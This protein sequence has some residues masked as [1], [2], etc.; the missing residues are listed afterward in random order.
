MGVVAEVFETETAVCG[1][2]QNVTDPQVVASGILNA[3]MS[4]NGG[5][6]RKQQQVMLK[7]MGTAYDINPGAARE[8]AFLGNWLAAQADTPEDAVLVLSH[9]L[10]S[11]RGPMAT[12]VTGTLAPMIDA[13]FAD[14]R[15]RVP[16]EVSRALFCAATPH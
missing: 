2:C 11:L 3:L 4:I 7:A 13:I 1:P 16:H 14:E 12:A 8:L 5:V 6:T 10:K 15:G 9:Q